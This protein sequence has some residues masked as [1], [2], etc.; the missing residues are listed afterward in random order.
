VNFPSS[1]KLP[2]QSFICHTHPQ[3]PFSRSFLFPPLFLTRKIPPVPFPSYRFQ[4]TRPDVKRGEMLQV[5]PALSYTFFFASHDFC[6]W[7]LPL[8]PFFP[9]IPLLP[10]FPWKGA[11]RVFS[12]IVPPP[13]R[14]GYQFFVNSAKAFSFQPS[15]WDTCWSFVVIYVIP[16]AQVREVLVLCFFYLF[17]LPAL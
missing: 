5:F 6:F 11:P 10:L 12:T 16:T 2:Y 3:F 13:P 15:Q 14:R 7:F 9:T 1:K 17:M 4:V 8:H